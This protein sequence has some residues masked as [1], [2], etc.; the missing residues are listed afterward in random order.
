[1]PFN[2]PRN[3]FHRVGPLLLCVCVL[4]A[5]V[6]CLPFMSSGPPS[7]MGP[8]PEPEAVVEKILKQQDALTKYAGR[9]RLRAKDPKSNYHFDMVAAAIQPYQFRIQAYD[10]MGRPV[11]LL[12]TDQTELRFLD[13]RQSH[14]YYG[15]PTP[16]N[17][18]RFIPLGMRVHDVITLF[19]GGQPL[20]LY[21][22]MDMEA[23]REPGRGWMWVL[24]LIHPTGSPGSKDLADPRF[25]ARLQNGS[26]A[27]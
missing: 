5:C 27:A 4:F 25:P 8:R 17:L 21:D 22:R 1:M 13:Y 11:L 16:R 12:T 3:H 20:S 9:G 24:N 23:K 7:D 2:K 26:G 15:P 14:L 19:A 6:S 18:R 10:P